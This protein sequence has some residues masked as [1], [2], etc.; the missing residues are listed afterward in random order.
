ML[1]ALTLAAMSLAAQPEGPRPEDSP[2]KAAEQG[3][4]L[5]TGDPYHRFKIRLA[6]QPDDRCEVYRSERCAV[7]LE[8]GSAR[9][10]IDGSPHALDVGRGQTHARLDHEGYGWSQ[11]AGATLLV[12]PVVA[13]FTALLG[14]PPGGFLSFS[15]EPRWLWQTICVTSLIATGA[16]GVVLLWDLARPHTRV[17]LETPP[18]P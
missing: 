12:A 7:P 13:G 10:W 8:P 2:V 15:R 18:R 16:A 11:L 3:V 1:F 9:L 17:T 6:D 14:S 4:E 5:W